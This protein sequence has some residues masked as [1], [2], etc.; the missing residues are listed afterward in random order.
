[1]QFNYRKDKPKNK[2]GKYGF[3]DLRIGQIRT[4]DEV[5]RNQLY[6]AAESFMRARRDYDPR[7][8][9]VLMESVMRVPD[10]GFLDRFNTLPL[11]E[12]IRF[13]DLPHLYGLE[14][15]SRYEDSGGD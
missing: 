11:K 4:Y 14:G 6:M 13:F 9:V 3:K 15:V 7:Y 1:M 5:N 8:I 2:R 10:R 12:R